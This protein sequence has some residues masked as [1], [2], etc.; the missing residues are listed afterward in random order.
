MAYH[1]LARVVDVHNDIAYGIVWR[2]NRLGVVAD[3]NRD[4]VDDNR[5]RVE[6]NRLG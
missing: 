4:R 6:D 1:Q 2:H 5:D 3:Y